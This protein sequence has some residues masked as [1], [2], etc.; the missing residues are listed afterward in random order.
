MTVIDLVRYTAITLA[1]T[2][3]ALSIIQETHPLGAQ[4]PCPATQVVVQEGDTLWGLAR[5]HGPL[6]ADPRQVVSRIR[7]MNRLDGCLIHPG[8]VLLVPQS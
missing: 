6:G 5:D 8:Q 2:V 4:P 7:E 1:L 3:L